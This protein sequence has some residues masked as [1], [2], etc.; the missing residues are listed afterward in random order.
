MKEELKIVLII[1]AAVLLFFLLKSNTDKTGG[2]LVEGYRDPI[3]LNR[4]KY[5]Y[6]YYPRA[7]GSIYGNTYRQG[8][9]WSVLSGFPFY[10]KAY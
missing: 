3:Y 8:G 4:A 5:A 7:N 6:D 10:D 9:S 2:S 1:L